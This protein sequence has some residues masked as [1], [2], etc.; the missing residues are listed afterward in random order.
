MTV[1]RS[2]ERGHAHHGWLE[3]RHTFSFAGYHDPAWMG[4][5]PLRVINEDRVDPGRGF[6]THGHRDMEILS[7]VVEGTLAHE[8]SSGSRGEL[9]PGDVQIMRAGTGIRHSEMNGS[10]DAPVHFLQIW[11][12]P[13]ERG[14][15]PA[16]GERHFPRQPGLTLLAS[17]DAREGS[18]PIDQAADVHRLMLEPGQSMSFATRRERVWLQMVAGQLEVAGERLSQGDAAALRE[19]GH[20]LD[21]R[22]VT[23]VEALIFDLGA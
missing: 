2:N 11:I 21:L 3:S 22:A 9:V 7:Y 8:D 6:S 1:R 23:A 14:V 17:P 12:E 4:F 19:P 10:K 5:G 13:A 18:L 15:A 20:S 16:Y